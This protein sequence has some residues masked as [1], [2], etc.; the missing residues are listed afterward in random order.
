MV[1]VCRHIDHICPRTDST[2]ITPDL[3]DMD[4][5]DSTSGTSPVNTEED[6]N[7]TVD[8]PERHQTPIQLKHLVD[9]PQGTVVRQTFSAPWCHINSQIKR[10]RM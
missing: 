1:V 9:I 5:G 7:E 8:H 6:T 10:G 2:V 3:A 4:Q